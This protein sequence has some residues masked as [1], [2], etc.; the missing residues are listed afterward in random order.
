VATV[1]AA[2]LLG[3]AITAPLGWIFGDTARSRH[4]VEGMAGGAIAGGMGGLIL[5]I[6]DWLA[7][8]RR[9]R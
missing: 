7:G 3:A 8:R 5:G 9:N 4:P 2:I 1:L 6:L